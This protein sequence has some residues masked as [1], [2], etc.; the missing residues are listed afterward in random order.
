MSKLM[1]QISLIR[2]RGIIKYAYLLALKI[3]KWA[4]VGFNFTEH[5]IEIVDI[6]YVAHTKDIGTIRKSIDSLKFIKNVNIKK[7]V[8]ISNNSLRF[9]E[10]IQNDSILFINEFDILGFNSDHYKYPDND[11][12]VTNRSPWFYQQLLKLGW[13]YRAE[14]KNYIVIDSD[15]YF[16]NPISFFTQK[17]KYIFFATEEWWQPYFDAYQLLFCTPPI[18][19]WSRVAHMMIFNKFRVVEMLSELERINNLSWHGAIAKS[20]KL[21]SHACFSEYET[22]ANWMLLN[23]PDECSTRPSYNISSYGTRR[24]KITSISNHSYKKSS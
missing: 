19:S 3:L 21:N 23:Y 7:I 2:D 22:Y 17:S 10:E 14:S 1:L 16:V 12:S 6:V 13:A 8:I 24:K 18:A 15:T 9:K 20:R 4:G 11:G 5:P